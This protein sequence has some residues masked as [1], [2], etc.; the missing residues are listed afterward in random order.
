MKLF[1]ITIKVYLELLLL[2]LFLLFFLGTIAQAG[3]VSLHVQNNKKKTQAWQ[4]QT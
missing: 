4:S 3:C 1:E 2:L